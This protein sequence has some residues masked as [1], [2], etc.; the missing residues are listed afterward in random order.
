MSTAAFL[1]ST[2]TAGHC[3]LLMLPSR[4]IT[5]RSISISSSNSNSNTHTLQQPLLSMVVEDQRLSFKSSEK[6]SGHSKSLITTTTAQ[7]EETITSPCLVRRE[8]EPLARS[9]TSTITV[10]AAGQQRSESES[11]IDYPN[12]PGSCNRRRLIFG[13]FWD[14]SSSQQQQLDL[15]AS[16]KGRRRASSLSS[17]TPP[18]PPPFTINQ[19]TRIDSSS[20]SSDAQVLQYSSDWNHHHDQNSLQWHHLPP[21][22]SPLLRL[23]K[24]AGVYPL[25]KPKSILRSGSH[26]GSVLS[27]DSD[28]SSF[29][30]TD[31]LHDALRLA[32]VRKDQTAPFTGGIIECDSMRS[33]STTTGNDS[34]SNSCHSCPTTRTVHFDPRV[35][36]TELAEREQRVWYSDVELERF[37][38]ETVETARTYLKQNPDQIAAY[39]QAVFDPVTKT[40]RKRALFSMPALSD[41]TLDDGDDKD[42]C[43]NSITSCVSSSL[44]Q[45][46]HLLA[47][48]AFDSDHDDWNTEDVIRRILIVDR[49]PWILDLFRRSVKTM[50]PTAKI[51]CVQT[52]E[53]ALELQ[54]SKEQP[55]DVVIAEE[56]LDRPLLQLPAN[57][58]PCTVPEIATN[59][60][61]HPAAQ[62]ALKRMSGSDLFRA[63]PVKERMLLIGVSMLSDTAAAS[64]LKAAGTD[65]VWGKPPPRMDSVLGAQLARALQAKQK[66]LQ[67][68]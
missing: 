13:S 18:T 51:Q 39:S 5:P 8:S 48:L 34:N 11:V 37:Q 19:R 2:G 16:P 44:D 4:E 56:R 49:N 64:S 29:N 27:T 32:A 33:I 21:L 22:P 36:V 66:K 47:S 52:A 1:V 17:Y 14:T 63:I 55:F 3:T 43:S 24:N 60:K 59:S 41:V 15:I 68:E 62:V 54:A 38:Q 26:Q 12:T 9:P 31:T 45:H 42:T 35:T 20:V 58:G 40:H 25:V 61:E 28:E 6:A 7:Q 30:L 65:F 50:F 10:T 53:A 46:L 67:N 57:D 23:R